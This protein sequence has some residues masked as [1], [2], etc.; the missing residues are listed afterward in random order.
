MQLSEASEIPA[1]SRTNTSRRPIASCVPLRRYFDK[2]KLTG[3]FSRILP[4][5]LRLD[6]L[7]PAF[8][9]GLRASPIQI[10]NKKLRYQ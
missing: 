8:C 3:K 4:K 5:S 7:Q 9:S 1:S 10:G 6:K 2:K